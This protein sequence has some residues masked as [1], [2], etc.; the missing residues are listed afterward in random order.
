MRAKEEEQED[1]I[2]TAQ[3]YTA[4][5]LK[6]LSLGEEIIRGLD[7]L[8]ARDGYENVAEAVGTRREDWT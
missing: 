1:N 3:A 7:T 2:L 8:L 4:L 5:A 6:G